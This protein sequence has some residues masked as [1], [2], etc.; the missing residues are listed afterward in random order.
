M[1]I[2]CGRGRGSFDHPGNRRMLLIIAPYKQAYQVAPKNEKAKIARHV[3]ELVVNQ[4]DV[5]GCRPRFI[6]RGLASENHKRRIPRKNKEDTSCWYELNEEEAMKKIAHTLREHRTLVNRPNKNRKEKREL[7]CREGNPSSF[8]SEG[9]SDS[10]EGESSKS[11]SSVETTT[12]NIPCREDRSQE[13]TMPSSS[14]VGMMPSDWFVRP[15]WD[16]IDLDKGLD[17]DG[18]SATNGIHD[19]QPCDVVPVMEEEV[20]LDDVLPLD[21]SSYEQSIH[22]SHELSSLLNVFESD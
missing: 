19:H 4:V 12:H 18:T 7:D 10:K 15:I 17:F 3:Y 22:N 1:D 21:F 16:L 11:L 6:R 2:L 13:F 8:L 20:L 14:V 9:E 5:D